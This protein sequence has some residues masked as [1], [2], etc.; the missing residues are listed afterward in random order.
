[1]NEFIQYRATMSLNFIMGVEKVN[2][3][4]V[5]VENRFKI[6]FFLLDMNK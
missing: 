3:Q 5:D 2:S 6:V 4:C 1:M